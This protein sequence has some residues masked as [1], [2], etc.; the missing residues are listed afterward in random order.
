MERRRWSAVYSPGGCGCGL[1]LLPVI[2]VSSGVMFALAGL[3]AAALAL[4]IVAIGVTIWLCR[5]RE[6]RRA[7]GKTN[8]GWVFF[9]VVAYLLSIS[10]L[11]FFFLLLVSTFT[12]E[13]VTVG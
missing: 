7:D 1:L 6:Q 9:L 10:Y 8:V 13:S 4:L 5:N 3:A 2:A 12:G 11:A